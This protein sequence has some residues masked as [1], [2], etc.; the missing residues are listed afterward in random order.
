MESK[1]VAAW[2]SHNGTARP[3]PLCFC[4]CRAIVPI[5]LCYAGTLWVGN[6]AYL[7]LSV[8]F[9]QMLKVGAGKGLEGVVKG[10]HPGG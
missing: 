6:A 9:I 3:Q 1:L 10:V 8:S 4:A 7:Y 5:G 2:G